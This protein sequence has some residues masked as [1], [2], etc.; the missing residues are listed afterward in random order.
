MRIKD[1]LNV[2]KTAFPMRGNLPKKEPEWQ[3]EW[4]DQQIYQRRQALNKDL[5]TFI[6]HDGPPY[7]NE[8]GRA[9]CRERV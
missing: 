3:Q 1:T 5:P 4:D 6:L 7:A 8:I 2:G 9:S